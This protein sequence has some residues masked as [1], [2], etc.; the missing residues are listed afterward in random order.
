MLFDKNSYV[1]HPPKL[2]LLRDRLCL[3]A[4]AYSMDSISASLEFIQCLT[5]KYSDAEFGPSF[6]EQELRA[7]CS[8]VWNVVDQL[9]MLRKLLEQLDPQ[10][11]G[12]P[13]EFAKKYGVAT[14]IRNKMDHL[15]QNLDNLAN[16]K[17]GRSTIFGSLS[18]VA[19]PRFEEEE[20]SRV[21]KGKIVTQPFGDLTHAIHSMGSV[22]PSGKPVPLNEKT[23]L[24]EFMAFGLTL[25]IY[26]LTNDLKTLAA[27]L[28]NGAKNIAKNVVEEAKARGE[29]TE[30]A[31]DQSPVVAFSMDFSSRA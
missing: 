29:N 7:L 27:I 18:Y 28:E 13:G 9:H 6:S 3:E 24:F 15:H 22:N 2:F 12:I 31:L 30:G 20:G 11:A 21:F 17:S 14:E 16:A 1:A 10:R 23:G 19:N 8:D 5:A 4:I 26:T 25:P